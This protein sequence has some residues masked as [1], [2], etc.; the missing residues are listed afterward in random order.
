MHLAV[1]TR[2]AKQ[3]SAD[4]WGLPTQSPLHPD[5]CRRRSPHRVR[6]RADPSG[7]DGRV[8]RIGD[9]ATVGASGL[10]RRDAPDARHVVR[11]VEAM[12]GLT[13]R[14]PARTPSGTDRRGRVAHAR[15][16]DTRPRV[17][18]TCSRFRERRTASA[19]A[20]SPPGTRCSQRR[21]IKPMRTRDARRATRDAHARR[22]TR[23]RSVRSGHERDSKVSSHRN[24][25][26]RAFDLNAMLR[27]DASNIRMCSCCDRSTA[28]SRRRRSWQALTFCHPA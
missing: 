9:R 22:A 17:P 12:A 16:R 7:R 8:C 5:T 1:D 10:R 21:P 14:Q 4:P 18:E 20:R 2:D 11:A 24:G 6:A 26:A 19:R 27:L 3:S 28:Q 13:S 15:R 25:A 23:G